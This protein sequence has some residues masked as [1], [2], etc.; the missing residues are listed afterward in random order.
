MDQRH[1]HV[2]I[3]LT[4]KQSCQLSNMNMVTGYMR[5]MFLSTKAKT[6]SG[7]RRAMCISDN[8]L[9][10]NCFAKLTNCKPE[11]IA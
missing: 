1:F 3:S 8:D 10:R 5:K 2:G 4:L 7:A 9:P 11:S 6:V